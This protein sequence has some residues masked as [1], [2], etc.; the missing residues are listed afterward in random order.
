M[1]RDQ[2]PDPASQASA[3]GCHEN[4]KTTEDAGSADQ[5]PGALETSQKLVLVDNE[6]TYEVRGSCKFRGF[7]RSIYFRIHLNSIVY[8]HC[9]AASARAPPLHQQ[10]YDICRFSQTKRASHVQYTIGSHHDRN[11]TGCRFQIDAGMCFIWEDVELS[12]GRYP[13]LGMPIPSK[14]SRITSARY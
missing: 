12:E 13:R 14:L 5:T 1:R 10:I 3:S 9:L 7:L 6:P 8:D 2:R 11:L 4:E